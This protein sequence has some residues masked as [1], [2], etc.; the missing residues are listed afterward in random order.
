ME[1]KEKAKELVNKFKTYSYY[2][3][4]DLTSRVKREESNTDSAKECATIAVDEIIDQWIMID[5]YIA[6]GDGQ[7]NPNLKYWKEVKQE[8]EKL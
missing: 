4:H 2:D 8:I 3:A 1:P 5:T 7:L 6:D